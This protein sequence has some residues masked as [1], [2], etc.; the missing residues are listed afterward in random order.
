MELDSLLER[1][2]S[3]LV[4]NDELLERID[5]RRAELK[6]MCKE[7]E[8]KIAREC[9]QVKER[10]KN[11][12]EGLKKKTSDAFRDVEQ[13]LVDRREV[14]RTGSLVL[15]PVN[16]M[17]M[18][19][20]DDG[21]DAII[22]VEE[23]WQKIREVVEHEQPN[24]DLK[25]PLFNHTPTLSKVKASDVGYLCM[26]EF[27]P[28]HFEL[29]LTSPIT[30]L[31]SSINTSK[32]SCMIK[33][34]Q[35]FTDSIQ[36]FIKFS[37]KNISCEDSVPF[38]ME[39][40]ILSEDKKSFSIS[41]LAQ[42][43]GMYLVTVLLYGQHIT[44]SPLTI[45][46][47][48]HMST[49][50]IANHA[51]TEVK[52]VNHLAI[53]SLDKNQNPGPGQLSLSPSLPPPPLDLQL[54]CHQGQLS[55]HKV[56]SL[57]AGTKPGSVCKPIGMCL[58]Q[59]RN[60]VVSSTYDD[61]VRMFSSNGQFLSLISV[62]KAP[63]TRPTDM[64]TLHSGQ[65]V[66]RDDNKVIIFNPEG[67]F[68]RTLWQDK[69]QVKCYGLAQDKEG[70]VI[71]IMETRNPK[72]TDLLFFDL[73]SGE[74]VRKIEMEDIISDKARSKCR[75]LTYQLDK[76]YITDLGLDC[77][78]ILDP[79][80]ISVKVFGVSGSG[81]GQFSDPAGLVVD[82]VGNIVVADSRNHR[83]CVYSQEGKF[84]CKVKLTPEARRPSGVVLDAENRELYVLNLHG[85]EAMTKYKIN[86]GRN[87]NK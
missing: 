24:I 60:I 56:L 79:A 68:L 66:V 45:P 7:E 47:T 38:C 6:N 73:G 43:S 85:R 32:V 72:K 41:F 17:I 48:R 67:K 61:K 29:L 1:I 22:N 40:S 34:D 18:K 28:N 63:F 49:P 12:G 65:F 76:L 58:L 62:P 44:N 3:K 75:F 52:A 86:Q 31:V 2:Q 4:Q 80:T 59:N 53:S 13:V 46:V 36:S 27:L 15:C 16:E 81:D 51:S 57:E 8:L 33:T 70:R 42:Q 30:Q 84:L 71:T 78:Y 9:E 19:L 14:V 87:E 5:A 25:V 55:C 23:C 64:V 11:A 20:S 39:D 54:L 74:L 50:T 82:R 37:I 26:A 21:Q 77:V 35:M 10:V 83:L 69:G